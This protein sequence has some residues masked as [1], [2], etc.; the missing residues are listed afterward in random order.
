MPDLDP[1]LDLSGQAAIVTGGGAGIGQ[2]IAVELARHG[3]DIV[4]VEIDPERAAHTAKLVE[5]HGRRAIQV[6]ADVMDPEQVRGAVERADA[7]LGRIDILVNNAGGVTRRRF[8]EQSE[9]SWRRHIELNFV[10]MLG[11]VSAAVPIMIRGGRGG[12][13]VNVT[14]IEGSRA[15]PMFSVYAA[16][17]AAMISFTR[18]M[19][20]ERGEH[21]IRIN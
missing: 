18:S 6:V 1:D 4:I 2:G 9:R 10:S 5:D 16:C 19:S 13:I 15:A 8:L 3:V 17:K 12:S 11:A 21:Q 20:L 7:E 14:S